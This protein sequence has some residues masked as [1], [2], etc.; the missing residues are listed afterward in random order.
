M[1]KHDDLVM[2]TIAGIKAQGLVIYGQRIA[3][4]RDPEDD[5][6]KG[7][8]IIPDEAKRKEPRG[9]V[10]AVGLG[11]TDDEDMLVGTEP[12]DRVMYT[13]YNPITFMIHLPDGQEVTLEL[14]HVSDLYIG[15]R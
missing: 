8:I 10:V 11:V 4:M 6:S 12:G 15:W 5:V 9:T 7:G 1:S 3:V 13:R 2:D 14:M